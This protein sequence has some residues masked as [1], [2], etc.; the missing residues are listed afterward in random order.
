MK[1]LVNTAGTTPMRLVGIHPT[2]CGWRPIN[3]KL[4]DYVPAVFALPPLMRRRRRWGRV[5]DVVG[6]SVRQLRADHI[7]GTPVDGDDGMH[8]K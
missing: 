5:G 8:R 3:L 6:R 7:V 4:M 2:G 1:I